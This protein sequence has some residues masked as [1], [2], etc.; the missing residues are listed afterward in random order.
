MT[1]YQTTLIQLQETFQQTRCNLTPFFRIIDNKKFDVDC[2][3]VYPNLFV[4]NA[5]AAKHKEYLKTIGITHVVNMAEG[6]VD[7]NATFYQNQNIHYFG[8]NICDSPTTKIEVHFRTVTKFIE[9]GIREGGRVLVHCAMGYSRSA[10]CA[11]AYLMICEGM[12]AVKACETVKSKHICRPNNG[13][14]QQLVN[15][16]DQLKD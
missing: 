14:L 11:I 10:T 6:E 16:D 7:T 12:S 13:F 8:V 2:D 3:E 4:G 1:E 9:N 15:L 5:S